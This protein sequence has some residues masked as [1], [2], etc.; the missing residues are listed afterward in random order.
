MAHGFSISPPKTKFAAAPVQETA[1][2]TYQFSPDGDL[3]LSIGV[4]IKGGFGVRKPEASP[5]YTLPVSG[6]RQQQLSTDTVSRL[7]QRETS[8]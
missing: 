8:S 3:L 1:P 5:V 2:W 6:G 4:D 7:L